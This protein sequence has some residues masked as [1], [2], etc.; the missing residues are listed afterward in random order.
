MQLW[1]HWQERREG[2]PHSVQGGPV[3][4]GQVLQEE[5]AA[6]TAGEG[7]TWLRAAPLCGDGRGC[8]LGV[9]DLCALCPGSDLHQRCGSSSADSARRVPACPVPGPPV[10]AGTVVVPQQP[11]RPSLLLCAQLIA[12][13]IPL[14]ARGLCAP[15]AVTV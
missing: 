11:P 1:Q 3:R 10:A 13:V 15:G 12:R 8:W 2:S 7:H 6:A 5:A 14:P 9:S 4:W